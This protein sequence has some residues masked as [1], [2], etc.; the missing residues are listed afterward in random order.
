M[1]ERRVFAFLDVVGNVVYQLIILILR[2]FNSRVLNIRRFSFIV[3]KMYYY[4]VIVVV[5]SG[6]F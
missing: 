2:V 6:G 3:I 1:I 4:L 5:Y